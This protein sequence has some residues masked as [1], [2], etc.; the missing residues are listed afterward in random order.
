MLAIAAHLFLVFLLSM[1]SE[2]N[3]AARRP[4]RL[5]QRLVGRVVFRLLP[6]VLHCFVPHYRMLRTTPPSA[7]TAAPLIAIERPLARKATTAATSSGVSKRFRSEAGR[8]ALK[9]S[10]STSA[11]VSPRCLATLETKLAMPSE[12]VGPTSTEFA[13]IPVP[14]T[15]SATPRAMA[16]CAVFDIP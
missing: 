9:N 5:V 7:L 2:R 3:H 12:A 15:L 14:A 13:V 6:F 4:Q 11:G 8:T 10:F 16:T 1:R